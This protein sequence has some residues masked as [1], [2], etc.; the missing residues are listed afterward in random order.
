VVS[1]VAHKLR[2]IYFLRPIGGGPVKIGCSAAPY[3]RLKL[4][5]EWSP[6]PL[7]IAVT[8]LGRMVDELAIHRKLACHRMHGEW[9]S[10]SEELD[11]L[12]SSIQRTGKIPK[13]YRAP[14]TEQA[15][16]DERAQS[17]QRKRRGKFNYKLSSC[18]RGERIS[19]GKLR[20]N[21]ERRAS[22]LPPRVVDRF[23][24]VLEEAR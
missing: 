1:R 13:A 23:K 2:L 14:P 20:A 5:A 17:A 21:A 7:E 18:E 22:Q 24:I 11:T 6:V 3:A 19:A 4:F 10:P 8:A 12:I 15:V 16:A 9:F